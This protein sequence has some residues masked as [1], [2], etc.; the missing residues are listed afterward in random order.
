MCLKHHQAFALAAPLTY[1]QLV[2][3]QTPPQHLLGVQAKLAHQ[4]L[5]LQQLPQPMLYRGLAQLIV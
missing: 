4:Q 1:L 2:Q 5:F 3:E